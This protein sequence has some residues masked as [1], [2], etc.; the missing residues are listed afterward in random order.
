MSEIIVVS[1]G[2]Q[3]NYE[4]GFINGLVE[5]V[6]HVTLIS[7]DRTEHQNI[8]P[9]VNNVNLRGSQH[10]ERHGFRKLINILHYHLRLLNYIRRS[11]DAIVHVIGLLEPVWF[12]GLLEGAIIKLL[13]ERYILTVHNLLPHGK[14]TRWQKWLFSLAYRIPDYLVVHTQRM[15]QQLIDD[16]GIQ[17]RK[18]SVMEHG[19][20]PLKQ[21]IPVPIKR[22]CCRVR[23]LFFGRVTE[24]KGVELLLEALKLHVGKFELAIIGKC[25]DPHLSAAIREQM[26]MHPAKEYMHWQNEY[27]AETAVPAIFFNADLLV[28]P[29]LKI[30]QSGVLFQGLRYGVPVLATDVG[31]LGSYIDKDSG[32][33]CKSNDIDDLGEKLG[34]MLGNIERYSR[35]YICQRAKNY[36]WPVVISSITALYR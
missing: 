1:H 34:E 6:N 25:L 14:N 21:A 18:V 5:N 32:C 8:S 10:E 33:V 26:A 36:E 11:G 9:A 23:I 15:R 16:F 4:K 35:E 24:Y 19:I 2:F 30:Y 3:T 22:E 29:Y 28:L 27:V 13:A 7:S 12:L 17:A 20:E 31:S